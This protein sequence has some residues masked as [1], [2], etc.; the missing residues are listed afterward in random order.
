MPRRHSRAREEEAPRVRMPQSD[1]PMWAVVP[2]FD[3]RRL[4]SEKAYRCPGCDL[5]IRPGVWHLVV[6]PQEMPEER[7]HWH[8]HCWRVELHRTRGRAPRS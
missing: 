8:E 6:V 7:R 1:A 5:E 2:G 3:M 4:A